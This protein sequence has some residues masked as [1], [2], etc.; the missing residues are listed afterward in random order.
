[1][2]KPYIKHENL[3]NALEEICF[4]EDFDKK[5]IEKIE[6]ELKHSCLI[7]AA[8]LTANSLNFRVQEE[9]DDQFGILF[10][11][12]D[13]F[14][15]VFKAEDCESHPMDFV[16]YQEIIKEGILDGF[17]LNPASECLLLKK[18]LFLEIDNLP[19]HEFSNRD[20]FSTSDLKSLKDSIDNKDMEDFVKNP[21]NIGNFEELFEKISNSTLLTLILS[22]NDLSEYASD[23]IISQLETGPLG[24]LYIDEIGGNYATVYTSEDKMKNIKTSFNKY[25]QIVNFSQMTNF[26]LNDDMDGIIINPNAENIVL[27]R[28][29]LL[30]YSPFLE[31][32][33]NDRRLNT[34]IFHIFLIEEE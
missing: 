7:I 19:E 9:G 25:S 1:M 4:T 17:I 2:R 29:V 15:K 32:T 24:F 11:D 21:K 13:E 16:L 27:S 30:K 22:N 20:A 14:N 31:R 12:M 6:N 3:R 28:D 23:G 8:D 5:V 33:C 18:D 26:V 10:T 34:A